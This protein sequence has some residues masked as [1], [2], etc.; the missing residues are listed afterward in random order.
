MLRVTIATPNRDDFKS[1]MIAT[2]MRTVTHTGALCNLTMPSTCYIDTARNQCWE[3]AKIFNSDYLLFMDSDNSVD[4]A[5]NTFQK[6]VEL[7]KDVVSG[8]Y[9]QRAF[10]YRPNVYEFTE[11]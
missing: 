10:P 8:V 11:N 3:D 2:L 4:Y 9:V 5:G 6:F 1:E 7:G